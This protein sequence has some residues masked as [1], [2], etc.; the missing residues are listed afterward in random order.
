[1]NNNLDFYINW[2]QEQKN[3]NKKTRNI[4]ITKAIKAFNINISNC[5]KIHVTGTNGKGS[6]ITY[7]E[8][9]LYTANYNVCSFT[10]PYLVSFNERIK[11]NLENISNL[12]L[13]KYFK[14]IYKYNTKTDDK[15]SFFELIFIISLM[16]F[17]IK[18]PDFIIIE[19]GI[20]GLLD[21]TNI[22][23]YDLSIITNIGH[24]HLDLLGGSLLNVLKNKLGIVKTKGTLL[25]AI[26]GYDKEINKYIKEKQASLITIKDNDYNFK[27]I[28]NNLIIDFNNNNYKLINSPIYQVK[29]CLLAVIAAKYFNIFESDIYLGLLNS[30]TYGRMEKISNNPA[31]IIDGAHNLE[32]SQALKQEILTNYKN[33]NIYI[34]FSVLSNKDYKSILNE[35]LKVT[36]NI[37]VTTFDDKRITDLN[38]IKKEFPNLIYKDSFKL[39]Y[40]YIIKNKPDLIICTGS[41]HFIGNIKKLL[42]K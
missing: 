32:A 17:T 10:S 26:K 33:K 30:K 7:L 28:N 13:L 24:D 6:T 25:T 37:I 8:N 19:V 5:T 12:D 29:N 14:K 15:L 18:K 4:R 22:L 16:H 3:I 40:D 35:L 34:I 20:G 36:K 21:V 31:I 2:A 39:S 27:Y 41:I 38:T 42:L 1:M 9:I 11:Y 23:K